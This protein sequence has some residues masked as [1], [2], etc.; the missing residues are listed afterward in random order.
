MFFYVSIYYFYSSY[1]GPTRFQSDMRDNDNITKRITW[2]P[3]LTFF[4]AKLP[5]HF[6]FVERVWFEF[7]RI[8]SAE[9]N[10]IFQNFRKRPGILILILDFLAEISR[11]FGWMTRFKEIQ[12]FVEI[13]VPIVPVSKFSEFLVEW[14]TSCVSLLLL[15]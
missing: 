7:S 14:K 6:S 1:K 10:S 5:G 11:T 2:S 4:P 12:Q 9:R 15:F 8:S 3:R 13:F